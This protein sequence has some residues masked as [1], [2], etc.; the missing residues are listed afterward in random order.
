MTRTAGRLAFGG[1]VRAVHRHEASSMDSQL[2]S[3]LDISQYTVG[4]YNAYLIVQAP[5]PSRTCIRMES[6]P[7][8]LFWLV[9]DNGRLRLDEVSSL[10]PYGGHL[11]GRPSITAHGPARQYPPPGK[12]SPTHSRKALVLGGAVSAPQRSSTNGKPTPSSGSSTLS[13]ARPRRPRN[14]HATKDDLLQVL[15]D[16]RDRQV[17]GQLYGGLAG[18]HRRITGPLTSTLVFPRQP[19]HARHS[20]AVNF[21]CFSHSSTRP[22][23]RTLSKLLRRGSRHSTAAHPSSAPLRPSCPHALVRTAP[24]RTHTSAGSSQVCSYYETSSMYL[25]I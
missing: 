24:E 1:P 23:T 18:V 13:L 19:Q 5:N 14:G 2:Y 4:P 21:R 25:S 10:R 15:N 8:R 17:T 20:Q 22:T 7:R 3:N 16:A 6:P 12:L 9:C 11:A